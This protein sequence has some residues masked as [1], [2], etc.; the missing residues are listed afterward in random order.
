MQE[1]TRARPEQDQLP[2]IINVGE[3]STFTYTADDGYKVFIFT[4]NIESI[5]FIVICNGMP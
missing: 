3:C 2:A 5:D 1:K 4:D